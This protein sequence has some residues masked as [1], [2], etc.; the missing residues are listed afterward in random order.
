[1]KQWNSSQR[2]KIWITSVS[3]V[4]FMQL[5]N[6]WV[7]SCT[8]LWKEGR[9]IICQWISTVVFWR[10]KIGTFSN[11]R[12]TV[13]IIV[14]FLIAVIILQYSKIIEHSCNSCRNSKTNHCKQHRQEPSLIG[15]F[16]LFP[17]LFYFVQSFPFHKH[18]KSSNSDAG[19]LSYFATAFSNRIYGS[20]SLS[21]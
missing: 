9:N 6:W 3:A 18:L 5:R 13:S 10:N 16:A 15:P 7:S 21:S 17:E 2:M 19:F 8:A 12:A 14:L 1:M 11:E 20:S 4:L